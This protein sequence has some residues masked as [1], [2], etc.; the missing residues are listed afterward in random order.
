MMRHILRTAAMTVA[1]A[2]AALVLMGAADLTAAAR[3]RPPL[4]A[5]PNGPCCSDG[6]GQYR[7]LGYTVVLED[8]CPG[9][10]GL[11]G[12]EFYLLGR[13]VLARQA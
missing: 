1:A 11:T 8:D 12:Y 9:S 6:A 4:F 5:R 7:G 13:Q 2:A 10:R 3:L